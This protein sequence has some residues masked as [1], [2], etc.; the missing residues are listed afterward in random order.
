MMH[1]LFNLLLVLSFNA[2]AD[3]TVDMP[4]QV[5]DGKRLKVELRTLTDLIEKPVPQEHQTFDGKYFKIVHDLSDE[6]ISFNDSEELVFKAATAYYH[7]SVARKFFKEEVTKNLT[8][9]HLDKKIVIRIDQTKAYSPTNHWKEVDE[10]NGASNIGPSNLL[11]TKTWGPE[12]WF[13]KA[14]MVKR[15]SALSAAANFVDSR[16]FKNALL[17]QM[18][19]QDL[20]S[21]SNDWL[22][23]GSNFGRYDIA[24]HLM[25]MVFSVGIVELLPKGI[26]LLGK[27]KQRYYLDTV[28]I[29]EI[30]Y[31][32]YAHQAL[33]PYLEH[34]KVTAITEGYPNYFASKISGLNKLG[35]RALKHNIGDRAKSKINKIMYHLDM[36]FS[37]SAAF[38]SFFFGLLN[39]I[40]KKLGSQGTKVIV[41]AIK[42]LDSRSNI[43]HDFYDALFKSIDDVAKNRVNS[44]ALKI[45][46]NSVMIK[47]GLVSN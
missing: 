1:I 26:K 38:G 35:A 39:D 11:S 15:K 16:D 40:E 36:E 6:A 33:A 10:F 28:L 20:I 3:F 31:H 46:L 21:F 4:V 12:I 32:E 7:L 24:G 34:R 17:G 41:N 37:K 47:R 14:K 19:L 22:I 42:Y 43:R 25:S 9:S 2:L 5:R 23:Q 44:K 27:I 18:L 30:I 45:L 29:P 8:L 13:H